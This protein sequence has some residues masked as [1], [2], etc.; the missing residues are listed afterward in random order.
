MNKN[1]NKDKER[2]E[3]LIVYQTQSLADFLVTQGSWDLVLEAAE[4]IK[5]KNNHGNR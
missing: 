5:E 3:A 1:D 4:K 2:L